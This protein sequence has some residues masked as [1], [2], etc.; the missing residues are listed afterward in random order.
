LTAGRI[1]AHRARSIDDLAAIVAAALSTQ[2]D[3]PPIT[4]RQARI[5]AIISVGAIL[6][7]IDGW[8]TG[9]I[10]LTKEEVVSWSAATAV[11][12][13]DAVAAGT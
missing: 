7:L 11:G 10:D 3:G 9:E 13:I 2:H 8:L 6:S 1:A 12:I 5:T 4:A